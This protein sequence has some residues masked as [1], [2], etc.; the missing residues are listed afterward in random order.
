M[1]HLGDENTWTEEKQKKY[2]N[3]IIAAI[4]TYG[5]ALTLDEANEIWNLIA[6]PELYEKT[7]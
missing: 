2:D 1:E 4:H 5:R 7:D 3:A 6:Y